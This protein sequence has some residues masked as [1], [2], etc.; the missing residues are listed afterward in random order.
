MDGK[1][2]CGELYREVLVLELGLVEWL[3][4]VGMGVRVEFE[5]VVGCWVGLFIAR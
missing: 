3:V 1:V 5:V 2:Y 4:L